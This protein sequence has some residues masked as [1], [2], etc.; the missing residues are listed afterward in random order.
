MDPES[1]ASNITYPYRV[2]NSSNPASPSCY[3]ITNDVAHQ[4]EVFCSDTSTTFTSHYSNPI[5]TGSM[6]DYPPSSTSTSASTSRAASSST[7]TGE[8]SSAS[9]LASS[10]SSSNITGSP[11]SGSSLSSGVI[12]GI[13]V[14]VS[15]LVLGALAFC[16]VFGL[17][18]LIKKRKSGRTDYHP[19]GTLGVAVV[20]G[21]WLNNGNQ[22]G[23]DTKYEQD[24]LLAPVSTS[25]NLA[26]EK[27]G[28]HGL[29]IVGSGTR[30]KPAPYGPDSYSQ[31]QRQSELDDTSTKAQSP[32]LDSRQVSTMSYVRP[33]IPTAS[34]SPYKAY[35]PPGPEEVPASL[36]DTVMTR[37]IH[38]LDAARNRGSLQ[39]SRPPSMSDTRTLSQPMAAEQAPMRFQ[40]GEGNGSQAPS[41]DPQLRPESGFLSSIS[42]TSPTSVAFEPTP[43]SQ[44]NA[45]EPAPPTQVGAF[46]AF[47]RSQDQDSTL[48][49]ARPNARS[50]HASVSSTSQPVF[51]ISST[52]GPHVNPPHQSSAPHRRAQQPSP[53]YVYEKN[54]QPPPN[55]LVS[56]NPQ[57]PPSAHNSR[58]TTARGHPP[59]P[60]TTPALTEN[61]QRPATAASTGEGGGGGGADEG[62]SARGPWKSYMSAEYAFQHGYWDPEKGGERAGGMVERQG[63][64]QGEVRGE[65]GG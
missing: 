41:P 49:Q 24:T 29:G 22:N 35:R 38:T 19:R 32:E 31:V 36:D 7:T 5:T 45:F 56:A 43:P 59:S 21:P 14:G 62:L 61:T 50:T 55:P 40:P 9:S 58:P 37:G 27:H 17:L 12:A 23:Q 4:Y 20:P 54:P 16:I 8:D 47:P 51:T 53:R 65:G 3:E 15:A 26:S 48:H 46:A 10:T 28:G 18:P 34:G 42:S 57:S 13:S 30:E 25:Q 33:H 44:Q 2:F 52:K 63:R 64:S 39:R 1:R 6:A 60:P 11:T